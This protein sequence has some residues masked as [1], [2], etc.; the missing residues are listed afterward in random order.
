MEYL[1]TGAVFSPDRKYRYELYRVMREGGRRLN[2]I[3]LNPSTAGE[4]Q[5][6][7]TI[8]REV[9]FA[10][11]W[12]YD[13]LYKY[14]LCGF[15]SSNPK[16]LCSSPDPVGPENN[17]YLKNIK[18][19]VLICWGSW[20]IPFIRM[21]AALVKQILKNPYCLGRNPDGEPKHPLYL[22]ASTKLESY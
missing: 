3:G 15:I 7:P 10:L 1:K 9:K 5:D 12:G 22:P 2:S 20:N 13:E 8:R 11:D 16:V 4:N 18:G 17:L 14:N 6:D 21:R 19:D